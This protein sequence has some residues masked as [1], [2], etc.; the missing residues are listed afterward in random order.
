LATGAS[1]DEEGGEVRAAWDSV[2]RR[3][4]RPPRLD[5]PMTHS[6]PSRLHLTHGGMPPLE[7]LQR[8]VSEMP[9]EKSAAFDRSW[10]YSVHLLLRA[11]HTRHARLV[12]F[13]CDLGVS[14]SCVALVSCFA[15]SSSLSA[16]EA[17]R[18]DVDIG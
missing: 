8:V 6:L 9:T 4:R 15:S 1:P 7:S 18:G 13:C 17:A 5:E 16:I 3:T 10:T 2:E 14:P 11:R 12:L